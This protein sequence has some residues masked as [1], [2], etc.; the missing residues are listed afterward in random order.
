MNALPRITSVNFTSSLHIVNFELDSR[1]LPFVNSISVFHTS[2]GDPSNIRITTLLPSQYSIANPSIGIQGIPTSQRANFYLNSSID[3]VIYISDTVELD[4]LM[5]QVCKMASLTKATFLC[6][7]QLIIIL[8]KWFV[9]F[10][11]I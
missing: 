5:S 4:A 2:E 3:N 11:V 7:L 9:T 1:L 8:S 10:V 6:M